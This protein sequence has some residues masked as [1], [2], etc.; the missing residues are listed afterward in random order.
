M[1]R[2]LFY[3]LLREIGK[4]WG[5]A[6]CIMMSNEILASNMVVPAYLAACACIA[7]SKDA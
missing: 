4:W 3:R 2:S 6:S 7:A 5:R 1:L